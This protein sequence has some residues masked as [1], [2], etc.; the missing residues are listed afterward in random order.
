VIRSF[1]ARDMVLLNQMV[2]GDVEILSNFHGVG[3]LYK[4]LIGSSDT[5]TGTVNTHSIPAATGIPSADR[6]G[7][8]LTLEVNRDSYVWTYAGCKITGMQHSFGTDQSSRVTFTFL[9]ASET[10]AGSATTDSYDT[11]APIRPSYTNITFDGT[12]KSANSVTI[13]VENPVDEEI[14]LGETTLNTEPDRTAVLRVTGSADIIFDSWTEYNLFAN[15]TD[16]S[17]SVTSA[18][19]TY[20]LTYEMNKCRV[21]QAT[22]HL[23]GRDRLRATI[24]WESFYNTD[25]TENLKIT[26][27]DENAT[28]T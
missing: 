14:N 28:L 7:L 24:E 19:S 4:H 17:I 16:T 27:V 8:G 12:T 9:G 2:R 13:T 5:T 26:V 11:L 20:S 3:L 10:T 6:I 23:S 22:P 21:T 1:S 18:D 25:A 15:A